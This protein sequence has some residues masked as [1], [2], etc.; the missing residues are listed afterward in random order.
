MIDLN[1][2]V[3]QILEDYAL[4]LARHPRRWPLGEGL[5]N[6][7]RLARP[8]E[9]TSKSSNS[10]PCSTIRGAST[11]LWISGMASVGLT[12]PPNSVATYS[13]FR[14]RL[15]PSLRSLRRTTPMA[16]EADITIQTCWD[17]DRLDLGRVG[18]MPEPR[19]SAR[20]PP[21]RGR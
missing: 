15:R 16:T 13:P 6:G 4:P 2:L 5:E 11:R 18:M 3:H 17:S 19:S 12:L 21:R 20:L 8:R 14:C 7:L 1:P 9:P 10:S